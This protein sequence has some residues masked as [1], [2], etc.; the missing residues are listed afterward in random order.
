MW[1]VTARRHAMHS[2]TW[3]VL[4]CLF[5]FIGVAGGAFGAHGLRSMVTP[6]RLVT[7]GTGAD[8]CQVHAVAL[9]AVAAMRHQVSHRALDI[10]GGALSGGVVVFTGS[11]WALVLLDVPVLGAITPIGGLLF[12]VGWVAAAIGGARALDAARLRERSTDTRPS[13][14]S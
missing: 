14:P 3:W 12:L 2:K 4:G 9:L 5:G 10:A 8:Y 6:E 1:R 13:T 11:L 7:W